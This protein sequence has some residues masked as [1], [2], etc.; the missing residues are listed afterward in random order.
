MGKQLVPAINFGRLVRKH[1]WGLP[2]HLWL[3]GRTRLYEREPVRACVRIFFPA[4]RPD[5]WVFPVGCYN[6]GTTILQELLAAHPEISTLPKEGARFT[7]MLPSPEDV[8]WIRMWV[9]CTEHMEMGSNVE[10]HRAK[11]IRK[12]WAPW[13]NRSCRV[14]MDKSVS[15]VTRIPWLDMNFDNA[16]FIGIVRDGYC[17]AEGIRRKARPRVEAARQAGTLYPIEMAGEQWVAS[18]QRLLEA[19]DIVDR[20]MMITYENLVNDPVG[21]LGKL[22]KFLGLDLPHMETVPDGIIIG[23]NVYH[24]EQNNNAQSHARLS[25]DDIRKLSPIIRDMQERLGYPVRD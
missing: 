22:W 8:G 5:L 17:A 11:R 23:K 4:K 24:V 13:L 9:R 12:D 3:E 20:F 14:F 7:A 21:L 2:A 18:N 25:T 19:A 6:S 15:N 16:Y 1:G 10:P